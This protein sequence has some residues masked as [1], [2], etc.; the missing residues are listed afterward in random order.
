MSELAC[1]RVLINGLVQGVGFRYFVTSRAVSYAVCGYVR[2]LD[3]GG[4]EIEV[5]GTR[6][7]ITK[8]LAEMRRGPRHG[9]VTDFQLEWKSHKKQYDHFFVKY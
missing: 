1:A 2:N 9:L 5:E 8:F 4:V 7:E 6:E 3:T